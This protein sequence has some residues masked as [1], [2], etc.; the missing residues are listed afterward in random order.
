MKTL[1]THAYLRVYTRKVVTETSK[2][3]RSGRTGKPLVV[4]FPRQQALELRSISEK[5]RV[6]MAH[7]VRFA[8][9]RLLSDLK[10]GQLELPFGLGE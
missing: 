1:D 10:D 8:V 2:R 5:R 3:N 6:A 9:D 4:Y 7:I